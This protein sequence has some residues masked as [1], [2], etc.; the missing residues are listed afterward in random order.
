MKLWFAFLLTV[1]A[2][3]KCA[4]TSEV[5]IQE[6]NGLKLSQ[7]CFKEN[8][9]RCEAFTAATKSTKLSSSA[10][11]IAGHPAAR[12]CRERGGVN[13]II[14][15]PRNKQYDYCQFKDGSMADTWSLYYFT[16]PQPK[17]DMQ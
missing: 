6:Y 4:H 13:R 14:G 12:L 5:K 8:I 15:D 9:P 1:V 17:I 2:F 7:D 10:S 11:G 3:A 16:Y